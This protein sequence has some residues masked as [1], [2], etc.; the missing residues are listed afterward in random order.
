[1]QAVALLALVAGRGHVCPIGGLVAVAR[2]LASCCDSTDVFAFRSTP[3]NEIVP[4]K[5]TA[6]RV[7]SDCIAELRSFE[8]D[9]EMMRKFAS[10]DALPVNRSAAKHESI[11]WCELFTRIRTLR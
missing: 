6:A 7:A 10:Y 11:P 8:G 5:K 4:S 1:M 2:A 3:S 9:L